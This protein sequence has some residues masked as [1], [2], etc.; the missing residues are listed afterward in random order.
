M[1]PF[2]KSA[3][4]DWSLDAGVLQAT[5]AAVLLS[6][7]VFGLV[8]ALH[9]TR[10]SVRTVLDQGGA[11]SATRWRGRANLIAL[12]V[13]VSVGLFL[14]AVVFIRILLTELPRTASGTGP[15]GL[16]RIAVTAIPFDVQ[17]R[18]EARARETVN[19]IFADA[20]L[21]GATDAVGVTSGL[22]FR[23]VR[24]GSST[25]LSVATPDHPFVPPPM[26]VMVRPL[27]VSA[28]MFDI[29]D[30]PVRF[31]RAFDDRDAAG[32]PL[33][34]M[35]NV[36]LALDLFRVAD[37]T[38]RDLLLRI[39]TYPT[40][41]NP[42]VER[43]T[44]VGVVAGGETADRRG[45]HDD[46]LYVPFTQWYEPNV[47]VV[48]RSAPGG[49]A[50]TRALRDAINRADPE[51]AMGFLARA[52]VLAAGPLAFAPY[53]A[54]LLLTM[55]LLALVLAM[56]GLYGVLSHVVERRR[57]ELGI[58]IALGAD[59]RRITTLVLKDGFR[60][61]LEGLFIGLATALIVRVFMKASLSLNILPLD[62][63]SWGLA[64]VLLV[65]AGA[66]ACYLPARRASRMDP[67]AALRDL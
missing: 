60:P 36:G 5:G 1:A 32:T 64:V 21:R 39:E 34:V 43:G 28:S 26:G 37:A 9:L 62:P 45:R 50:P 55:A 2:I 12:Q 44:I 53:L 41:A 15:P 11:N 7:V 57:R 31:G 8:P 25:I 67:N 14:I 4:I 24:T 17:R 18:D 47:A 52:D 65:L 10:D 42:R 22:P 20:Q 58:R 13:G 23:F 40:R 38:G 30:I 56:A 33:T 3:R 61:I 19:R 35:V 63:V 46:V 54:S 66:A 16:D 29:L 6:I 49:G 27:S 51:L 59:R 48:A